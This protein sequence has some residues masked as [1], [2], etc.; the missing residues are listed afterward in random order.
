[1]GSYQAAQEYYQQVLSIVREMGDRMAESTSIINLAWVMSAQGEWG[2]AIQ[3]AERGIAMK[4]QFEQMEARAEGLTWLGH[5]RLGLGQPEEAKLA[6]QAAL[7]IREE[8]D[9]PHFVMEASAGIARAAMAQGDLSTAL[10]QIERIIAYLSTGGTLLAT[11]EPL[12]IYL[13]CYRGLQAVKDQRADEILEQAYNLLKDRANRILDEQD[14]HQYEENVPWHRE[15][16]SEWQAGQA[17]E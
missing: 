1:L 6:Y 8:L 13:T 5:A 9:Q 2:P 7:E 12:R 3:F 10:D 11:W 14:R 16:V 17:L 15:I 4:K